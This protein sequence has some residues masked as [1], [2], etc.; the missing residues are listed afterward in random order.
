[1]SPVRPPI[2]LDLLR[3]ALAL[4]PFDAPAAQRRMYPRPGGRRP[5]PEEQRAPRPASALLYVFAREGRLHFPLTL[6][7]EDLPEHRGQV[8]LP[9]GRPEDGESSWE[10][11]VRE[12]HEEIGL[13]REL[14]TSLGTLHP[15]Y[16]PV[17]HTDLLVHVATGPEP[18]SLRAEEREVAALEHATLDQL[19]DPDVRRME[20]WTRRG[21]EMDVPF[22]ALAG[23]T[24]WGAT[25]IALA[26]L[27]ERLD[28]VR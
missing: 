13:A 9:G 28:A 16:I 12:A 22:F 8:S 19:V 4:E 26:E 14:P 10:T 25:A 11:A 17:T 2:D 24:V 1:M 20:R 23:W 15:V 21:R 18:E 3:A 27:A 7:R 5:D 6:R